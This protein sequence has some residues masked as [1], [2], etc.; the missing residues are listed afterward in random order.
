MRTFLA[1]HGSPIT[2]YDLPPSSPDY[3]PIE[4]LWKK[5]KQQD[6]HRHS[7]PSFESLINKVDQALVRFQ[8]TPNQVLSLF[9]FSEELAAA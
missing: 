9:G 2:V 4:K 7:F 5:I 6:P 1:Q 3:N 8:N